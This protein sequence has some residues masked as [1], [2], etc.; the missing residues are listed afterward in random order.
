MFEQTA[1]LFDLC[2]IYGL[3]YITRKPTRYTHEITRRC[4]LFCPH[5]YVYEFNPS[6]QHLERQQIF[7]EI[8][9][10]E[11]SVEKYQELF[12]QEIAQGC[13]A[14]FLIGG[15]PTL[16]MDVIELAYRLFGRNIT[17][18]SNGL[19]KI[20]IDLKF[21]FAISVDGGETIHDRIRGTGTW[22]R[23]FDNYSS[24]HRVQLSC[25]LRKG[26]V[27]QIQPI[28]DGWIDTN[29]FGASFFF[30]TPPKGDS[31]PTVLSEEREYARK[32]LH[33]VI[34]EYPNF[35]RM[36]HD[37]VDLLCAS[38]R[39]EC[40]VFRY[41]KWYDYQGVEVN[42]CLLGVNAD[43]DL[44]GCISPLYLTLLSH[45]WRLIDRR[46]IDILT[47]PRDST[48]CRKPGQR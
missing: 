24:D 3:A 35:V 8:E 40:P 9:H 43:C 45:W 2:K 29:V 46:M 1:R 15:E 47:L 27:D 38:K 32:E 7:K 33:R 12:E 19:I 23:I 14:L 28:I 37:L 6:Y 4:N 34:D 10:Q 39:E 17:L 42:H 11:L 36:T 48:L 21:P 31:S 41:T 25:C 22:R 16:R 18:I 13:R 5:C 30:L 44:C 26:T 20:P